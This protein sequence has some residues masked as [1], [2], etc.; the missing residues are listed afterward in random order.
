MS[1]S[2]SKS[3]VVTS[4]RSPAKSINSSP[5]K[6]NASSP[7]AKKV[8]SKKLKS[9]TVGEEFDSLLDDN[10]PINSCC[11]CSKSITNVIEQPSCIC[12]HT[13]KILHTACSIKLKIK[14]KSYQICHTCSRID[15]Y[16]DCLPSKSDREYNWAE[17]SYDKGPVSVK[18]TN[19]SAKSKMVILFL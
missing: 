19:I 15:I 17:S 4:S 10:F 6:S 8:S 13:G 9:S 7:A 18:E 2:K 14:N 5:A 11:Y 12:Y 1:R 16:K 3:K